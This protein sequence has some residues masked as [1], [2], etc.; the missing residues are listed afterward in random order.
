MRPLGYRSWGKALVIEGTDVAG[1]QAK[2]VKTEFDACPA[3]VRS[4]IDGKT[5]GPTTAFRE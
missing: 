3:R 4:I 1:T 2:Q 5:E